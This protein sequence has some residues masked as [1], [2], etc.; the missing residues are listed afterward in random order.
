[1]TLKTNSRIAG[2]TYLLYIVAGATGLVLAG[3]AVGSGTVAEKLASIAQHVP[4]L[5]TTILLELLSCF[6]ALVLAVTLYAITRQVDPDLALMILVFRTAEGVVGGSSMP[7]TVGQLWLGTASGANAPGPA[8]AGVLSTLMFDLPSWN[9]TLAGSFFA[10]GSTIFAYL[11][12]RG[13]LVP[14]WLAWLGLVAS[15]LL[16][17]SLPLMHAGILGGM[18]TKLI[19]LPMLA[20][21]VPLGIWLMVKGVK[22]TTPAY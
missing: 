6:C 8:S 2:F 3:R 18:I 5:R 15:V 13:R 19:W 9:V 21:E 11:L 20:F 12:V 7:S 1:M 16:V 22:P 17:A 14:A 10:V 4:M